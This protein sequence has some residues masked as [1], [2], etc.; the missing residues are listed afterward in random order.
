MSGVEA[1]YT[2]NTTRDSNWIANKTLV[3]LGKASV[4]NLPA[5]EDMNLALDAL[6]ATMQDLM[7]RGVCYIP[8]LNQTPAAYVDWLAE[9]TAINLKADYGYATPDDQ[10]ALKPIAM[11]ELALRRLSADVPS[12]GPQQVEF[13]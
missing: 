8:D 5:A 10:G 11:V 6:D 2:Y 12:Y 1:V 3:K 4:D 9:R 7:I 13:Y